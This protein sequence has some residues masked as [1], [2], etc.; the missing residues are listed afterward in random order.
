MRIRQ[1][2]PSDYAAIARVHVTAFGRAPEALIVALLRQRAAYD[3]ALSL[4]AEEDGRVVGHV[5]F[6][7]YRM[8]LLG[9]TVPIVTLAPLAVAPAYQGRG[10][11]G[12]L[13]AAGHAGAV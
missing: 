10:I 2:T 9:Q 8:Q 4:V 5:L 13:I 12:A 3:P 1:E 11:G 6:S 7:P